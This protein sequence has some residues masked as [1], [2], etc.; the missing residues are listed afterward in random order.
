M[1][2][3]DRIT[4]VI[5]NFQVFS[6]VTDF[7]DFP[8]FWY[9]FEKNCFVQADVVHSY[10]LIFFLIL[11][12]TNEWIDSEKIGFRSSHNVCVTNHLN[13]G[14]RSSSCHVTLMENEIHKLWLL[15]MC[16]TRLTLDLICFLITIGIIEVNSSNTII[17]VS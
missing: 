2:N 3:I 10:R 12:P 5:I 4:D 6:K 8:K 11:F 13:F 9:T 15:R 16:L 17:E 14:N 1:R 7:F